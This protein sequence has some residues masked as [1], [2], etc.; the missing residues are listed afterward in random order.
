MDEPSTEFAGNLNGRHCIQ[1]GQNSMVALGCVGW[2][3]D[4]AVIGSEAE[5]ASCAKSPGFEA[6][7]EV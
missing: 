4:P 1:Y 6:C 3:G 7:N 5:K 2:I